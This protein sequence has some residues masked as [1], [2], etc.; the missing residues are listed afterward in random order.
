MYITREYN[1][2]IAFRNSIKEAEL[3][4]RVDEYLNLLINVISEKEFITDYVQFYPI[5]LDLIVFS[6]ICPDLYPFLN[7]EAL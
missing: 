2:N 7:I 6:Q 4:E 1:Y 5:E 3:K